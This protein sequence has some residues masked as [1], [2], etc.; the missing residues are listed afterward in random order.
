MYYF[1]LNPWIKQYLYVYN[2][3]AWFGYDT[4]LSRADDVIIVSR[5]IFYLNCNSQLICLLFVFFFCSFEILHARWAM[6]GA[7]G[8][9]IPELLE[10]VGAFHFV[11]PVWWRV[12]YSKL[13]V[14]TFLSPP[15]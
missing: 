7:L 14:C 10:L 1:L 3:V 2:V 15:Y 4:A 12:G 13:K 5:N 11:E 8:A 6:L 9:L